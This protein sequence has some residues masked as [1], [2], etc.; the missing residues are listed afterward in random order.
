LYIKKYVFCSGI[1]NYPSGGWAERREDMFRLV[2]EEV[3]AF[4]RKQQK[5][6]IYSS[7]GRT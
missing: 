5:A 6:E 7:R 1:I 2:W 3:R 4:L